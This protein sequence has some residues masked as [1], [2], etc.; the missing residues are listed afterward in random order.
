[1]QSFVYHKQ[2]ANHKTV[3]STKAL[4]ST[5]AASASNGDP[6]GMSNIQH[7]QLYDDG[8]LICVYAMATTSVPASA[9]TQNIR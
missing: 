4:N 6:A 5:Q 1:M 8:V 9:N 7:S 2:H 3:T